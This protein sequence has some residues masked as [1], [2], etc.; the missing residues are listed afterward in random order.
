MRVHGA[1]VQGLW[2]VGLCY[3]FGDFAVSEFS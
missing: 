3:L 2:S 1:V